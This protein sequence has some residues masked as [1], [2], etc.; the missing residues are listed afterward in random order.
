MTYDIVNCLRDTRTHDG[1]IIGLNWQ[2]AAEIERLRAELAGRDAIVRDLAA[3][4]PGGEVWK[5]SK[6][7]AELTERAKMIA[8]RPN[9]GGEGV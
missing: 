6:W 5:R 1:S 9:D 8:A 4:P 3:L 7:L 2:A